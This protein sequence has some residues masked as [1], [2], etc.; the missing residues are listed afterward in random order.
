MFSGT[1]LGKAR[2]PVTSYSKGG[3]HLVGSTQ[4]VNWVPP[5]EGWVKLNTDGAMKRA[6]GMA[7]DGGLVRDNRGSWVFGFTMKIGVLDN[8]SAE[9]WGLREGLRL[10]KDRVF[11]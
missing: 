9:L 1:L 8:F 5:K 7:S 4:W 2:N 11:S 10:V 3:V 6:S